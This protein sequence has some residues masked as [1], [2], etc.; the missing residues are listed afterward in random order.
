MIL[1]L[2]KCTVIKKK[3]IVLNNKNITT[4]IGL[5]IDGV[6]FGVDKKGYISS[7]VLYENGCYLIGINS[8]LSLGNYT[9][10][11]YE[12]D[13]NFDS[14]GSN[15]FGNNWSR[16]K[17]WDT[18]SR[19]WGKY[20]IINDTLVAYSEGKAGFSKILNYANYY[21]IINKNKLTH[22]KTEID[23]SERFVRNQLYELKRIK[24]P[25]LICK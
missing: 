14:L 24:R 3:D 5:S 10:L 1:L 19:S 9:K 20:K 17:K 18:F 2:V 25:T 16:L 6:F 7:F 22:F 13:K 21:K 23:G 4:S 12:K 11:F 8:D 15:K